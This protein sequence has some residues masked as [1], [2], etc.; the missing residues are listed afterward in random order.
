M[1]GNNDGKITDRTCQNITNKR[2]TCAVSNIVVTS[3]NDYAL[4]RSVRV[5]NSQTRNHHQFVY[6]RYLCY[7]LL[8]WCKS[9]QQWTWNRWL[10]VMMPL[11][12]ISIMRT[13]YASN[14]DDAICRMSSKLEDAKLNSKASKACV[15]TDQQLIWSGVVTG[16]RNFWPSPSHPEAFIKL[17]RCEFT[18]TVDHH[19]NDPC[20][21]V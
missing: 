4:C 3:C 7:K 16:W 11:L 5:M 20:W 12:M 2:H 10:I 13:I 1:A 15:G 21:K 17:V 6:V 18:M 9:W 14:G 19:T 8:W